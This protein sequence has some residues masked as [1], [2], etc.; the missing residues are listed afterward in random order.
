MTPPSA[1]E[2]PARSNVW[3]NI[4]AKAIIPKPLPT[5]RKASRRVN[6]LPHLCSNISDSLVDKE[7]FRRAEQD[8][9][10]SS[11]SGRIVFHFRRPARPVSSPSA[12]AR[13][14]VHHAHAHIRVVGGGGGAFDLRRRAC[15]CFSRS[16]GGGDRVRFIRLGFGGFGLTL[17]R[18]AGVRFAHD[19]RFRF[20][21]GFRR[22]GGTLPLAA[23][24]AAS[25]LLRLLLV[26]FV[27]LQRL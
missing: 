10:V 14:A 22:C 12:E 7:K 2:T 1:V 25:S 26:L 17:L 13:H 23:A 27:L 5:R 24:A 3:F 18:F 19:G 9:C 16:L 8:L 21:S 11:P 20:A 15:A 4:P 6:G